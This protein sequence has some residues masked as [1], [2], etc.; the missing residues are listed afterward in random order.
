MVTLAWAH[1]PHKL[2]LR[3]WLGVD[4]AAYQAEYFR[5]AIQS[6]VLLNHTADGHRSITLED[7]LYIILPSRCPWVTA[8]S[9]EPISLLKT[10]CGGVPHRR[11]DLMA[12]AKRAATAT[13][14]PSQL[15]AVA[16]V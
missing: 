4:S 14:D 10:T 5:G 7:D 11:A 16:V 15:P 9:N 2:S 6:I 13:Y 1:P 12:K 8:W 3:T